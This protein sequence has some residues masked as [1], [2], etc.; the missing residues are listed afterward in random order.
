MN[1]AGS[2]WI[3]EPEIK[4]LASQGLWYRVDFRRDFS[5][6]ERD[7]FAWFANMHG[8]K[9][10]PILIWDTPR[11]QGDVSWAQ[12]KNYVQYVVRRYPWQT[13]W[14]IWNEPNNSR[15]AHTYFYDNLDAW[16]G[17]LRRTS[18]YIKEANPNAR[19]VSGGIA[20]GGHGMKIYD[21][22]WNA[23][24]KVNDIVDRVAVHTYIS[25]PDQA[26]KA[27][28]EAK[29]ISSQP[30]W[31]TE[32]GRKSTVDGEDRQASWYRRVRGLTGTVPLYWYCL[33]DVDGAFDGFGAF[34]R[35]WTA[36]PVWHDL[37]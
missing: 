11:P 19:V 13:W 18:R 3:T 4:R 30:V 24:F 21:G 27:I 17:F 32:L 36:K 31:C 1:R 29:R 2:V 28:N 15:V 26:A 34:R 14:Q 33:Q 6:A 5:D 16:R 7:H 8:L 20:A 12:W 10:L 9:F 37:T 22:K 25:N 23:W 35:D